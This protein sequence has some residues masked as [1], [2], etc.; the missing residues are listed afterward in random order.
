MCFGWQRWTVLAGLSPP[1]LAQELAA[2]FN[3][4]IRRS[5]DEEFPGGAVMNVYLN[6]ERRFAFVELRS[7]EL[8]S[9]AVD[10]DGSTHACSASVKASDLGANNACPRSPPS[11]YQGSRSGACLSR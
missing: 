10:L 2:F 6:R 11:A 3:D 4:I 1:P 7:I 5:C 8:T 9:A